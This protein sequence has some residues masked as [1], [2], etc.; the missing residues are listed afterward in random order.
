MVM[1]VI[2]PYAEKDS[3]FGVNHIP[4]TSSQC[5]LFRDAG[6]T[7]AR[8]CSF[9]W[10]QL[11]P[12]KGKLSFQNPDEQVERTLREGFNTM[13]LLP[14]FP[15][16]KWCSSAP[17]NLEDLITISPFSYSCY[18]PRTPAPQTRFIKRAVGRFR[19]RIQHWEYV[20]EP[21]TYYSFPEAKD[22]MPGA[23][24]GA[25]D[26][27]KWLEIACKAMRKADPDCVV[28]GGIQAS[29]MRYAKEFIDAG[30]LQ[31]VDIYTIHP[32]AYLEPPEPLTSE[33]RQ[34]LKLMDESPEGRRPI[35]ATE[36]GY[37]AADDKPWTPWVKPKGLWGA[38]VEQPTERQA[39]DYNVRRALIMLA[40]GVTKVFMHQGIEGE[41]NNGAA[42][43]DCIWLGE[44]GAPR[45]YYPALSAMAN[46]LGPAPRYGAAL[47]RPATTGAPVPD[48]VHGYA[49]QCGGRGVL[50]AW[51]AEK[52]PAK[53]HWRLRAPAASQIQDIMGNVQEGDTI[54]LG[55]SPVYVVSETLSAAD[56]A[57][58]CRLDPGL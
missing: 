19:N 42:N 6:V 45:K 34:L 5:A 37:F 36:G 39:A 49:F 51:A 12:E 48:T 33:L 7:W 44:L 9:E 56:L 31:W 15:S 32:Y 52:D 29:P 11:E 53:P 54:A 2:A 41:V 4:S 17:K 40:N 50:A 3:P 46:L 28:M 10:N 8:D 21:M 22:K 13:A 57:T 47:A 14:V 30:G 24:Y 27:V 16:T 35:W 38:L 18:P 58:A 20:N 1:A 43:M 23:D 25:P 26:Y 55:E